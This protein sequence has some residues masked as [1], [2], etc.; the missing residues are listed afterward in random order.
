MVGYFISHKRNS[1]ALNHRLLIPPLPQVLGTT[2]LL[3]V[4]VDKP[5]VECY[6][7]G[8]TQYV[9]FHGWLLLFII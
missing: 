9:V 4:S 8:T 1:Y 7:N 2:S 3:Y 5:V 6:V